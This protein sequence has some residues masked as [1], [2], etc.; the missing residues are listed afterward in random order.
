IR[1]NNG[2]AYSKYTNTEYGND[3]QDQLYNLRRDYG[4]RINVAAEHPRKV[5][6]LKALLAGCE[7]RADAQRSRGDTEIAVTNK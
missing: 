7:A 6:E 1:P 3:P 5:A 2:A 4:E